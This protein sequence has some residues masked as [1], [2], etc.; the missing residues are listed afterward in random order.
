MQISGFQGMLQRQQLAAANMSV[1]ADQV[2]S[3]RWAS[4]KPA[5]R[6]ALATGL[7][8]VWAA[9]LRACK[10]ELG[11]LSG[12]GLKQFRVLIAT[13]FRPTILASRRCVPLFASPG[14]HSAFPQ[15]VIGASPWPSHSLPESACFRFGDKR[16]M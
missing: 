13:G 4:N 11:T 1:L 8:H 3:L 6:V 15:V 10:G 2:P 12:N 16:E 9:E 5:P 14:H 7:Q